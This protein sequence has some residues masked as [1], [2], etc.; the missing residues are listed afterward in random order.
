MALA[1]AVLLVAVPTASRQSSRGRR[2]ALVTGNDAYT[3][4]SVLRNAVNDARAVA[5]V[6]GEVGFAV[7]RVERGPGHG[8][9][10]ALSAFAGSDADRLR[11]ADGVGAAL[12]RGER[13]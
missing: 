10:S 3:D 9:T 12:R 1:L 13:V 8:L 5:W 4:Q 7:T 2:L 6:P 11:G